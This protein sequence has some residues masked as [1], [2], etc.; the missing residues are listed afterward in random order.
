[1][2]SDESVSNKMGSFQNLGQLAVPLQLIGGQ[3]WEHHLPVTPEV[4]PCP[5]LLSPLHVPAQRTGQC[6]SDVQRVLVLGLCAHTEAGVHRA[7]PCLPSPY[8]KYPNIKSSLWEGVVWLRGK[9]CV[10]LGGLGTF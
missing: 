3:R 10:M 4:L 8:R 7:C 6:S 1:M 5:S 9:A 2:H